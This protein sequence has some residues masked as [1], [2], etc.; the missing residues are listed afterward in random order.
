MED[1]HPW[2]GDKRD[3]EVDDENVQPW[4]DDDGGHAPNSQYSLLQQ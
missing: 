1:G 3:G 4:V 2:S